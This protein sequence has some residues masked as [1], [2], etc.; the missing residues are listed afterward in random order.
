MSIDIINNHRPLDAGSEAALS[1]NNSFFLSS[2]TV[3]LSR[4]SSLFFSSS[5]TPT[6]TVSLSHSHSHSLFEFCKRGLYFLSVPL[7]VFLCVCLCLF[8]QVRVSV[9]VY[10]CVCVCVCVCLRVFL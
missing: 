4:L 8:V 6:L 1:R 10:V 9:I 3:S 2:L 7:C 5:L